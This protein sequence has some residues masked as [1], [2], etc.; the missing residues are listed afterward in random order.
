MAIAVH[1]YLIIGAGGEDIQQ[2]AQELA[3]KLKAKTLE[4][5]LQ[6]IEDARE[7]NSF[8]NLKMSRPTA[9][10]IKG[11][12]DATTETANAFLKNLEEP[13]E[14]LY[15][16]LTA[17][18][19]KKVLPTIVSRCQ[20]IKTINNSQLTINNE[21]K[22]FLKM[23]TGE[24]FAFLDG[25]KDRGEAIKFVNEFILAC[26]ELVHQKES[27]KLQIASFLRAGMLTLKNL[28]ANGNVTLQLANLV[29]SLEA[30]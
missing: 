21:V 27:D 28:K 22:E 2:K 13:Q 4:F 19:A 11:I 7:L 18:S 29:I 1:A 12:E 5:P 20:V 30:K 10:L 3:K 16:I 23:T 15:Y 6:K 26:H 25:I 14:N 17:S 24:K 9:I 8:T